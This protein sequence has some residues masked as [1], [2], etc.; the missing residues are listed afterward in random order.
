MLLLFVLLC[1]KVGVVS[2]GRG[3]ALAGYPGVYTSV[4][5]VLPFIAS[6]IGPTSAEARAVIPS[7]SMPTL[8]KPI[9]MSG[10]AVKH[11]L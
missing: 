9:L 4:R 6:A 7:P 2:F 10:A 1:P 8:G 11:C 3:C 5:A